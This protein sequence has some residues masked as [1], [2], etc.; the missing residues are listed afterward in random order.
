MKTAIAVLLFLFPIVAAATGPDDIVGVWLTDN[1][2]SKVQIYK[3]GNAYF[4]KIIWLK[5]PN[6][7]NGH[8][9]KDKNN[10]DASKRNNPAI[11]IFILKNI[12][13]KDG[14]WEGTIYGPKRGKEV[15]CVLNLKG[16]DVL[17]GTAS[18]GLISGSKTWRRAK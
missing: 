11:G 3:T 12:K 1:D 10:P 18:Y 8:P 17:E 6:N 13:Y 16:N 5:E 9:K 2:E 7:S 15:D 4:G 14:K